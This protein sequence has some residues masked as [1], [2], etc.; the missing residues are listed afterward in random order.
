MA[1]GVVPIVTDIPTFRL[2]TDGGCSAVLWRAGDP[3]SLAAAL[4]ALDLRS[5]ARASQLARQTFEERLSFP[6][7]VARTLSIYDE[8]IERRSGRRFVRGRALTPP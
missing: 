8:V 7:I 2:I 4:A 6:A 3:S 5:T 1:C